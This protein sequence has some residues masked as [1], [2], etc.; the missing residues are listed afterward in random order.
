VADQLFTFVRLEYAG[1]LGIPDGRYLVREEGALEGAGEDDKRPAR[2]VLAVSGAAPR[3][4][5]GLLKRRRPVREPDEAT[6]EGVLVTRATVI[7]AEPVGG[8]GEARGW[9]ER[10]SD[11]EDEL[12]AVLGQAIAVLNR[13]LHANA[14]A[15]LDPYC[16]QVDLRRA[17]A[18]HIGF[19]T[20]G[21][22]TE[23][24]WTDAR[25]VSPAELSSLHSRA[26]R[27]EMLQPQ[28]RLAA[29]LGG[30]ERVPPSESFVLRA[31][32][33]LD[34]GRDV[35]AT[36]DLA[37]ALELLTAELQG[38]P[39]LAADLEALEGFR[40]TAATDPAEALRLAERAVKRRQ[41]LH[42]GAL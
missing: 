26:G 24:E 33:D 2:F 37:S 31:R 22:L 6:D 30:R 12:E 14:S 16:P 39:E 3:A 1:E 10:L 41:A 28:E 4:R 34:A 27:A 23:E 9:L 25:A 35:E 42:R 18:V 40:E 21:E 13:A 15:R 17:H 29:V 11:D 8:E 38:I 32:A 19:A 7:S 20:G 36:H 5:R